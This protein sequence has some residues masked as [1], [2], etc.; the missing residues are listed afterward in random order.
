MLKKKIVNLVVLLLGVVLALTPFVIAP[1]CPAMANGMRMSCYYS[2]L[3]ATYVGI[4]VV[5][6]SLISI[7]VNNN[8]P[9]CSS[10]K[11]RSLDLIK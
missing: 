4:G 5:V 3:L 1:V 8:L 9:K 10:S 6:I 7:F 2:G 11:F